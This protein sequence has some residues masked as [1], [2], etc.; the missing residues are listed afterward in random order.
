MIPY[1]HITKKFFK[2]RSL[3][4]RIENRKYGYIIN[5]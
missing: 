2:T 3:K 1:V 4:E 5:E